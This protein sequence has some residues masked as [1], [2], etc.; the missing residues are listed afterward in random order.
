MKF[1]LITDRT[2]G[3]AHWFILTFIVLTTLISGL[4]SFFNHEYATILDYPVYDR[5]MR[6]SASPGASDAITIVDIDE[7]SLSA[8]GQ[9]PWPRY[10][11]AQLV[12]AIGRFKPRVIGM[13]IILPEPDR[14]SLK[15]IQKQFKFDFD[16]PLTFS[17]APQTLMDNDGYLSAV[18]RDHDVVG[19][20]YFYFDHFNKESVCD[21]LPLELSGSVD[22]LKLHDATGILCNTFEI[23]K[24]YNHIGF[25]NNRYDSDGLLRKAP[26]LLRYQDRIF[27][28]FSLAVLLRS[29]GIHTARIDKDG[30]GYHILAGDFKI[31]IT[32]D[33][34][35]QLRFSG[36][37]RTHSYVSA[38]EILNGSFSVE[39]LKN[40]TV[41]IGSSAVGLSDRHQTLFDSQFPGVETHAVVLSSIYQNR[42]IIRPIW[43]PQL[44]LALCLLTG[45]LMMFMFA[46]SVS[47]S[48]LFIATFLWSCILLVGSIIG[49]MGFSV[50]VPPGLPL[51]TAI[52]QFSFISFFRYALAR[53]ASF[54]WFKKLVDSQQLT[55][56]ALVSLVE[57]RDSET[58]QHIK[59]TQN[60][61]RALA[62]YLRESG[63][64]AN[65]LTN[66]Y[67]EMLY[68]SV[69]LH[70]IGK[71]GIPDRILL[72]PGSLTP[73]E[74][75]L[76]KLHASYGRDTIIRAAKK[77]KGDNYL[78]MGAEIAGAHHERWDGTGYP[79]GLSKDMIPLSGRIMSICD[80]YDALIS[81]RCYK[82]PFSHDHAM[83]II[84]AG[85]SSFFD[86]TLVD[87]FFAIEDTIKSI[88]EEFRDETEKGHGEL[89][90][91][92]M[93]K[94][95]SEG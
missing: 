74:F 20:R 12:D 41:L 87:A 35:V 51:V 68:L 65:V 21:F 71:V 84:K 90:E 85:Q 73:E 63:H 47:P 6:M 34:Y 33:G 26:L 27:A 95:V 60:Y 59:R 52:F 36:P 77:I 10:R 39:Q 38:V 83:T 45:A 58:G 37:S 86:P 18:I 62:D 9:W 78:K 56:E 69:P 88:A 89:R 8:V 54:V 82:Q 61:A 29:A 91:I 2:T 66:D 57:T 92:F 43:T 94:F 81:K 15:N 75:E 5:L 16:L 28:H 49:F 64:F 3:P 17:G 70:D 42:P 44:V 22:A 32:A 55:I 67:I 76:M 50:Y 24:A 48:R 72:K 30:Y 46:R 7:K 80:V 13:D 4:F 40:H 14:T 1:N 23:E 93:G 11:L 53:R 19:S 31:P 25:T 79:Q